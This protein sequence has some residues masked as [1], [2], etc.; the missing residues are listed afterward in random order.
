MT[1]GRHGYMPNAGYVEARSAVADYLKTFNRQDFT[2]DD[3]VMTAGACGALHVVFR[4]LLDPGQEVIIPA[5]YFVEYSNIID[6]YQGTAVIVPTGPGFSLYL[7]VVEKALTERTKAVLINTPNNPTG[8]VYS[9]EEL[10]GLADLLTRASKKI[11]SPVYLVSDEPYRKI[12]YDGIAVPSVFNVYRESLVVTSFSK[13][14]SL[15]GERIGYAA[16]NP[17]M[18]FRN[19]ISRGMVISNRIGYVN[20]PALMQRAVARVLNESVDVRQYQKKRDMLCD[21]L[22]SYGYSFDRPQGA[23][24]LF[25]RSLEKDDAAFVNVL[26][27]E[28]ILTVPG[29]GFGCP[30]YF[31]IA[32]CVADEVIERALPGFERVSKRYR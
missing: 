20:A 13:D 3:V 8:K 7:D 5:P 27:E 30:G 11:G 28:N 26:K 21:A 22:A 25:P 24:Y 4:T 23:F 6:T 19:V 1:P 12:V 10:Q 9:E 32:Y 18:T 31:R 16:L 2:A 29:R 14:L 15:P 17:E